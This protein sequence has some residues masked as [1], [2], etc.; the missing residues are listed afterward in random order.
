MIKI[1]KA[2]L[3]DFDSIEIIPIA[4]THYGDGLTDEKYINE[5]IAYIIAKP[6][7]FVIL[8]GDLMNVAL[9]NSKSDVYGDKMTPSEQIQYVANKF[10]PLLAEGRILAMGTG[11]HEDRTAKETSLDMSFFLAKEMGIADRYSDKSFLIYIKFGNSVHSRPSRRSRNIYSFFVWHGAGGG[12]KRTG[13]KLNKLMDMSR[14]ILCDVYVMAHDHDPVLKP[15]VIF[16]D[17][18]N[19]MS[20]K[21]RHIYYVLNNA[22]QNFGGYGQKYGFKPTSTDITSVMLNGN[23]EK[24]VK[25]ITGNNKF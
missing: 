4:D 25:L 3:P 8:N 13:G 16:Q 18:C 1:I 20:C 19:N 15:D 11:N 7:R 10:K 14:T 22:W 21:E 6:N 17:D 12:G 23:G 9:K 24:M 5:I 2:E